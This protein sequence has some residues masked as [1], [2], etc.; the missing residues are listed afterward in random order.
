MS[1]YLEMR[2]EELEEELASIKAI[3]QK[4]QL[5]KQELEKQLNLHVVSQQSELLFC[6][7]GSVK[8]GGYGCMRTDCD[9]TLQ[10]FM[11]NNCG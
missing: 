3:N 11:Q 5:D 4:L 9:N 7:C 8:N 6:K 1:V 10:A 2:I